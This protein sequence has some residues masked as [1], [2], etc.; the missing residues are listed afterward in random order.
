VTGGTDQLDSANK[1]KSIFLIPKECAPKSQLTIASS[2]RTNNGG[3]EAV[4]LTVYPNLDGT[5]MVYA[6]NEGINPLSISIE[7]SY[8]LT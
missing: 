3:I 2:G 4:Q 1:T 7:F 5:A 6:E 8:L